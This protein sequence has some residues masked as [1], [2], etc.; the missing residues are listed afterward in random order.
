[1]YDRILDAKRRKKNGEDVSI[2][3]KF[4][5]D[6]KAEFFPDI[7]GAKGWPAPPDTDTVDDM[8]FDFLKRVIQHN[9]D[10]VPCSTYLQETGPMNTL[11]LQALLRSSLTT[12]AT[13]AD[14][15]PTL[16]AR[17]ETE[18]RHAVKPPRFPRD[19]AK[20]ADDAP[21]APAAISST[22]PTYIQN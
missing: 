17:V 19:A 15:S 7:D 13:R 3:K 14:D 18:S 9:R 20:R 2:A 4:Y 21:T 16:P 10:L 8:L 22:P 1:M 12:P 11:N 6:L 5:A